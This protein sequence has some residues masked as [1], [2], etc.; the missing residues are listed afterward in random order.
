[1]TTKNEYDP[2]KRIDRSSKAPSQPMIML[3]LNT[4]E[5]VIVPCTAQE[6]NIRAERIM[7]E[8][9]CQGSIMIH[10]ADGKTVKFSVDRLG[11]T[12]RGGFRLLDVCSDSVVYGDFSR[13]LKNAGCLPADQE[14]P[15]SSIPGTR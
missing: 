10:G 13:E 2:L 7:V 4:G 15:D 5:S 3:E 14:L 11:I 8:F 1:M 6:Y 9:P 12:A